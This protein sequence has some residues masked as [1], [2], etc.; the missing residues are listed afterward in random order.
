MKTLFALSDEYLSEISII[1]SCTLNE[2]TISKNL[3]DQILDEVFSI[4]TVNLDLE[5]TGVV[6]E[7]KDFEIIRR[8]RRRYS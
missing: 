8:F 1:N 4:I 5:S 6:E 3:E 2:K 7:D